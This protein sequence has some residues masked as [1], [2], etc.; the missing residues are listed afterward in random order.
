MIAPVIVVFHEARQGA[1]EFPSREQSAGECRVPASFGP[2]QGTEEPTRYNTRVKLLTG[3]LLACCGWPS[4]WTGALPKCC[5]DWGRLGGAPGD[6]RGRPH[7]WNVRTDKDL[8]PEV[9]CHH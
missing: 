4:H 8:A 6:W 5:Q 7:G 3:G 1:L 2:S 9:L